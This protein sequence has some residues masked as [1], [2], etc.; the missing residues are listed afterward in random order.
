MKDFDKTTDKD[1][2]EKK[3]RFFIH[4]MKV[5]DEVMNYNTRYQ[6]RDACACCKGG[7]REKAVMK[8]ADECINKTIEEKIE[9]LNLIT[10]MGNPALNNDGTI[11][12]GIGGNKG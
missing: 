3:A 9:A 10:H 2:K 6:V 8:I 1:K 4:A 7:W 11:T 12:A 5:M